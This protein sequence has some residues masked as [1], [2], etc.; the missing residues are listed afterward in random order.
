MRIG[1]GKFNN[2]N[3]FDFSKAKIMEP[4]GPALDIFGDG[5]FWAV[6]TPGH[7]EGHVSYLVNGKE[8]L[9][10][11]VGDACIITYGLDSGIGPGT[12]S[13]NIELAQATLNKIIEFH[14][15]YPQVKLAFGHE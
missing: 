8:D 3:K 12:Y 14:K 4:L 5:S 11:I 10:L 2:L 15:N 6:S 13:S 9:F 7:T 1:I